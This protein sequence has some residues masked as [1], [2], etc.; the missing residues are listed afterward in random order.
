M[1]VR[2]VLN[3][4]K[5]AIDSI[6]EQ[7]S[8]KLSAQ[9]W[10]NP[11]YNIGLTQNAPVVLRRENR[12]VL[13]AMQWGFVNHV[14]GGSLLANARIETIRTLPTFR[15]AVISRRCVVPANGFF[16]FKDLGKRKQPYLFMLKEAKP[17]ALAGIWKYVEDL[18]TFQYCV[19]T[20]RPN[21]LVS[22]IHNRMP[23]ILSAEGL[24]YWLN[25]NELNSIVLDKIALSCT[26]EDMAT[27]KVSSYVNNVRN[28]GPE[29]IKEDVDLPELF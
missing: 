11:R 19:L 7:L 13:E 25:G 9:G 28:E 20:T 24:A 2:Y 16:E 6:A 1:C 17:M 3:E 14:S 18:N 26:A 10:E 29:C 21:S 22:E 8:A 12:F 4:P 15:D 5:K 27:I 23:V